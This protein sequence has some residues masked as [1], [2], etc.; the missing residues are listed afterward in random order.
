MESSEKK[1]MGLSE[2]FIVGVI[3]IVFLIMGY[4]TAL[5]IHQAAVMKIT[6]NRD[7]P[8]TVYVRIPMSRDSTAGVS[9]SKASGAEAETV[10][11]YA[12]H[13][14]RAR[15]VRN[16]V[17][18]RTVETFRFDPNT[19]SVE[20]L[21]LLGFSPKQ[22]Q[23]IDNYRQK[24]GRF[25]RK[26]DFAKSYVVADSVFR[27]LEPF[28]DIPLVDL[29]V[30]DSAAFDALPG[31]GGWFATKMVEHRKALGG[32][33]YKEQLMDIYRFDQEKF[34][35]LKDLITVSPENAVPYPLWTLP[36]DSLRAHPYIRNL[37]T[38]KA[39]VLYRENTPPD[40]WTI[41]ALRDAGILTMEQYDRLS[42]CLI[43]LH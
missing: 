2:S 11:R 10:R 7:N 8:D 34:D 36:A 6:A 13:S 35:G 29:N 9:D 40:R 42:P 17:P 22:A 28:I 12:G 41:E 5:F 21:C 14:P 38:A 25:R 43:A 3:A 24:G 33:S 4:Q 16:N 30:A 23:A 15:A 26:E 19:V 39:I 37:E 18:R 31:I 20:D 27:R 32:Y 1:N